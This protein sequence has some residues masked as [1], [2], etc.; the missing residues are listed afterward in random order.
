[1]AQGRSFPALTLKTSIAMFSSSIS[2]GGYAG[3]SQ[4]D[5]PMQ[6]AATQE[7]SQKSAEVLLPVTIRMVERAVESSNGGE[8]RIDGRNVNTIL[9]VGAVE[10]LNAQNMSLEC[11]VNDATGKMKVRY[12]LTSP[13]MQTSLGK[14]ENGTYVSLVGIVK[15]QPTTH[16]SVLTM[17]PVRSPD[18]ISYHAIEVAHCS[19]KS[20][21]KTSAGF[22][23]P[24]LAK[25]ESSPPRTQGNLLNS[26]VTPLRRNE[27][28]E[29]QAS[30]IMPTM[31]PPKTEPTGPLKVRIAKFLSEQTHIAE[32]VK[33]EALCSSFSTSKAE[34]VKASVKELLDE[35]SAY[36]T[37]DEEHIAAI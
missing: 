14:V 9:V 34:E 11:S 26:V 29:S 19:L 20:K 27:A 10:D 2:F 18:E 33:V 15:T 25:I 1:L 28:P 22:D 37:I 32:G 5:V 7:A 30:T 35:G 16:I 12:Y 4:A 21:R 23:Q 24:A 6:L 17:R 13:E 31:S 3:A 36:T 8:L